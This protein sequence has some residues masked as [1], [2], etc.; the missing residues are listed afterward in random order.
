[1]NVSKLSFAKTF[2]IIYGSDIVNYSTRAVVCVCRRDLMDRLGKHLIIELFDCDSRIISD[3]K[4]VEKH[5]IEAVR[6][7]GATIIRSF[8]HLF[9][10]GGISGIV[11]VAE[12]HFSIHTWPEYGYSALDIF[13]CGDRIKSQE[14]LNYLKKHLKAR[15]SSTMEL[16]RGPSGPALI[17]NVDSG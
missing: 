6:L 8:F 7:S 3:L 15:N 4:A 17:Q 14:A 5:L 12:S 9:P 13:T 1:L 10:P 2:I 11:V 16:Q